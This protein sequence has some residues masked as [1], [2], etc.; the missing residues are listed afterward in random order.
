[1]KRGSTCGTERETMSGKSVKSVNGGKRRA[2]ADFEEFYRSG[3]I[4]ARRN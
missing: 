2:V 3:I 1:M 4:L